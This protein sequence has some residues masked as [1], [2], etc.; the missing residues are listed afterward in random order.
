MKPIVGSRRL[1][2]L[3]EHLVRKKPD[4][5]RLKLHR[6]STLALNHNL[7]IKESSEKWLPNNPMSVEELAISDTNGKSSFSGIAHFHPTRAAFSA[8]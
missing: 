6:K 5:S 4:R 7:V 3:Q 8:I 1:E 2:N